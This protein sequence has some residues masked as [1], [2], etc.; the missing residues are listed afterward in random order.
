M[1]ITE[2]SRTVPIIEEADLCVLGGSC[3]GV[4]AAVRAAR[5]GLKTVIIEKQNCFGGVAT[6]GLV[7]VWHSLYD[8]SFTRRIIGGL[9][10][11]VIERLKKRNAVMTVKN[12]PMAGY[13]LNTEELKIELDELIIQSGVRPL[14]HTFYTAPYMEDKRLRGVFIENKSGRSVVKA[15]VFIDATGD[16]DLCKDLNVPQRFF[17]AKQPPTTCAKIYG[18]K[19]ID[20]A[21]FNELICRHSEEFSLQPDW[22]WSGAIPGMEDI[23]FHAETH[24]FGL[25][26]ANGD[27]LTQAEIEGRRQVR[28]Y[29]DIIRKYG[30]EKFRDIGLAALPSCIGIRETRHF[31]CEY[32]ITGDDLMYGKSFDD[33]IA[34]GTY[35]VDIHHDD[36]P[37]ITLKYLNG[38][39]KYVRRG[40]PAENGFWRTDTENCA[41]YYQIPYR[42]LVPVG[43]DNVLAAGRII[44]ADPVAYGAVRVMVNANQTGEAAGVAAYLMRD[45]GCA[46]RK[47][48]A[49]RL[50]GLLCEGGSLL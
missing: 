49:Q 47:V 29:M 32:Q 11:E 45:T 10:S 5:L 36:K 34:Y 46:S 38:T 35:P 30:P 17:S 18:I 14:L 8:I 16:G 40:Y 3:T 22:G 19:N 9:T 7:N 15:G 33:G 28:A 12:N 37:G 23:T 43:P 31:Q 6:A 50:R 41:P 2:P 1:V 27:S 4:F 42:S 48:D 25:D 44:D 20:R 26:P 21:L 24:V 39:Q 13:R